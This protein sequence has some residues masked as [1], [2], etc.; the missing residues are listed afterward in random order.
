VLVKLDGQT[1]L[2]IATTGNA[3]PNYFMLIPVSGITL[4][5]ARSSG[6]T[7]CLSRHKLE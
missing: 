6:A 2:R 5:A 1:T 7:S 3:N 4:S